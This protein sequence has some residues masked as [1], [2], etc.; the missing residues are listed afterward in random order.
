MRSILLAII[1]LFATARVGHA[2]ELKPYKDELFGYPAILSS[3]DDGAYRVIDYR[4]LRDVNGR[5]AEPRASGQGHLCVARR[6]EPQKDLTLKSSAGNV[7]FSIAVRVRPKARPSSCST[8]TGCKA[9][10]RRASTI[11]P[12]AAISTA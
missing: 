2:A 8:F 6:D 10:A 1:A 7:R 3:S 5:D 9:T 12:S 11:L 4:E